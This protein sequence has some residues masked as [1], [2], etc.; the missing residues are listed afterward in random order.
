MAGDDRLVS[1]DWKD[2]LSLS[3]EGGKGFAA[4]GG[5]FTR[6]LYEW[7]LTDQGS[8]LRTF[9]E[10]RRVV[11]LGAGMMPFG[12]GLAA[13]GRARNF[14]AVEP[15]Y[16]DL[17]KRSIH[18]FIE[19][20]SN[21]IPRI[22][23]KVVERDM[24]DYLTDEPDNLLCIVCCGIESCILPGPDYQSKVEREVARTLAPEAFFISS[25]SDLFP[26]ALPF[27]DLTY[28]RPSNPKVSDRLRL[29]GTREAFDLHG[30]SL[31]LLQGRS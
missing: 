19:E 22:P 18:S 21:L 24:L 23:H 17:Q 9:I 27:V 5:E 11:E 4:P 16:A 28:K 2:R 13:V 31:S 3:R 30:E 12:Y 20:N 1:R 6:A 10:G 25:H 8:R 14:V 7:S 15:F 26:R 29:H